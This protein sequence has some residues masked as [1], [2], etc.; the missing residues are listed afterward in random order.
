MC[1]AEPDPAKWQFQVRDDY[2]ATNMIG[3]VV[4]AIAVGTILVI[5]Q[6]P[7]NKSLFIHYKHFDKMV[8]QMQLNYSIKA[9]T[10]DNDFFKSAC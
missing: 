5:T 7:R 8:S 2:E 6:Y 1:W 3:L 4:S 9:R 10:L